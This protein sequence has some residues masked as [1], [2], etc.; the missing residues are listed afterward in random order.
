M[1]RRL[2]KY[3]NREL[4]WLEFNQRVLDE[5]TDDRSPLLER[6]KFL[7][8]TASNLDEFFMVR[9]GGL[10]VLRQQ[11]STKRDPAKLTPLQ[12]LEAVSERTHQMIRDQYACLLEQLEPGLAKFGIKR[13]APQAL[14]GRQKK[15]VQ[16]VF[17]EEIF[18]IYTPMAVHG[19]EEF[20]LVGNKTLN[21]CV[22][23][24]PA[25]G[26]DAPR[27]ALIPFGQA[28]N[29]FITLPSDGGY[30]YILLEDVLRAYGDRYFPGAQ[31]LEV[32]PF[33]VTRNADL[34]VREDMASDLL[35]EMEE[36]LEARKESDCVRLEIA[37]TA[38]PE[39]LGF[40][41]Q[42]LGLDAGFIYRVPGPLDL[43]AFMRLT[44]L[45]DYEKLKYRPWPPRSS[46]DVDPKASM[47][48]VVRAKD[49]LL[50]RPFESFEP[51]VRLIEEA[52]ADPDVLAIKIILYRTSRNSPIV[53][54]LRRAAEQGKHV[55]ALVELKARFD[56]ARN[57]EW[58]KNLEQAGVQVVYGVK[59]LKTH[60]KVCIIIRREPHGIQ[61]YVHFST[62]NYNE[63]T[64]RLYSDCCFLTCNE[65][66]AAD[67]TSFFNAITGYS[68]PQQLHKLAAAPISLRDR[69][70]ELVAAEADRKQQ[71]QPAHIMAQLNSLADRDMID[72][73]Y[74][75]S[76]AGVPIDLNV[77][78]ICCLRPGVPGLSEN[79]RVVSILDRYLE[80][81]RILYFEHGGDE[82]VFISSADW[83]PRNLD[84]RV[85]LLVPVE[86]PAS[87]RRLIAMLKSYTRDNVQGRVLHDDGSYERLRPTE[88]N[89]A[90]QHQE[91][92]Y[93]LAC[94][95]EK[96]REQS[97]RT[98]FEPYRASGKEE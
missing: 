30:E 97:Q 81:S 12:Q 17:D 86:D 87:R 15:A 74:A 29:R 21:V 76:Q 45:A 90:H 50:C 60:A 33:R 22:R 88:P 6:L 42:A 65:D 49:I 80:H 14:S 2:P 39:L 13:V 37:D 23:L 40:L 75:A 56:E 83:M 68:Q 54:A 55:T 79:I 52:A 8:I 61:R 9:V 19:P 24:M 7:A 66:L 46:V 4:S 96:Q 92:L 1:G 27:F 77:R 16:R 38:S 18:S 67:A 95:A 73:L 31:V 57:I 62:G 26:E 41:Q 64:A 85:E 78:G 3:I 72:A 36:V 10:Q 59:N 98:V 35:A 71:G 94:Q 89:H 28:P 11:R 47:F 58:A 32:T 20:P 84:R 34:S 44:G 51:V 48:D 63:T 25:A 5:A 91:Y 69:L 93:E 53:A 70:L 43:S 82:L